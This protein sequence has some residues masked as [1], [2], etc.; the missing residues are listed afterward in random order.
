MNREPPRVAEGLA[1]NSRSADGDAADPE[2]SGVR[3]RGPY[4]LSLPLFDPLTP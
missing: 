2:L 4:L 3:F 1:C